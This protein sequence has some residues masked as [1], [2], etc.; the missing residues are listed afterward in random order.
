MSQRSAR[1]KMIRSLK[2]T[3]TTCSMGMQPLEQRLP[4]AADLDLSPIADVAIDENDA[5]NVSFE[6]T[7]SIS[8]VVAE[9]L[10]GLD[11]ALFAGSSIGAFDPLA[12]VVFD[13]DALTISGIAGVVGTTVTA[14]VTEDPAFPTADFEIA[15]FSF[16]SFELDA[17]LTLTA[18]GSRPFAILSQS[19]VDISG[20][21]DVSANGREAGAGGGNGGGLGGTLPNSNDGE[22][23][24]GAPTG[25]FFNGNN[26]GFGRR[27]TTG[28]SSGGEG[29][30]GGAFGG[31]G[32]DGVSFGT[33]FGDNGLTR[34]TGGRAYGDL[35]VAIQGGSGGASGRDTVGIQ[36]FADGGG[37]G[38]GVEIGALSSITI[39]GSVLANGGDGDSTPITIAAARGG[40]G[41]GGGV[42]VHAPAVEFTGV[43]EANGGDAGQIGTDK[44]GGG[45][46]AGRVLI[47]HEEGNL[48]N[49]GTIS[50]QGGLATPTGGLTFPGDGESSTPVFV[51]VASSSE[52]DSYAYDVDLVDSLG[53]VVQ[54][55][56]AGVAVSESQIVENTTGTAITGTVDIS[57]LLA[58]FA[59]DDADLL[60]RVTV[61]DSQ[62]TPN[63]ADDTFA[64]TVANVAPT[65]DSLATDSPA[66]GGAERG[67]T[68]TLSATFSDV[69]TLD[70]HTAVIDWGDGTTS[71]GVIDQVAGTVTGDHVYASG[72]FFDVTVTLTD[73]D[74]GEA[75]DATQTVI[76]GVGVNDGELQLIGTNGN[77]KFK[78]FNWFG[79]DLKVASRL[80]GGPR[81]WQRIEGPIDSIYMLLGDGDDTG[82][83]SRRVHV[84]ATIDAGA[85]DDLLIGGNGDDI[86]LGGAGYDL[87]FGRGGRDLLIGGTGGDLIF[88][89]GGQ[90]ILI[91]GTTAFDG[92]RASLDAIMAEWT[93]ERSYAERV[94]NLQ[95]DLDL[96]MDGLNG[97]IYLIASGE[98]QTVFDDESTDWLIGGR[99][100]DLYF[101]GEDDFSLANCWEVVE[102]IEAEEPTT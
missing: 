39:S 22:A 72:G 74:T 15:V 75:T 20:V 45:G 4:L 9:P 28:S 99:G 79:G 52:V 10:P 65:I 87:M 24:A 81:E 101:A 84:D 32:G 13:T 30:G 67:E 40:G 96:S 82:F 46:G 43:I 19:T 62:A 17:G 48:I 44:A 59:L 6:F 3:T 36:Q 12:N 61:S 34:D 78:V 33:F 14:N 85:G 50:L 49:S 92:D 60:V 55:L 37:G 88:G 86:L 23:A 47:A 29:G 54:S 63:M 31:G 5:I 95:G 38:G 27:D 18:V 102:E 80:D 68:V 51:E 76:A 91:A 89:D 42:L 90:D 8:S 64:L 93:S 25:T 41:A 77:D 16:D 1:N 58:P 71:A 26:H 66:I 83:V 98:D 53:G 35:T 73:D 2:A 56:A 94:D 7:D 11:P 100:R 21:I 70:T 69:G 57:S 97:E